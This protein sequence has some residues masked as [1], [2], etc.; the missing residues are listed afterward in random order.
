[1]VK[2]DDEE[3]ARREHED[4]EWWVY[5]VGGVRNRW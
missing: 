5:V 1:V 2:D 3:R 4:V